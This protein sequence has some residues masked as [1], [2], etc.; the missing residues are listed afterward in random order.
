MTNNNN[1]ISSPSGCKINLNNYGPGSHDAE[2]DSD[3]RPSRA[4]AAAATKAKKRKR[5]KSSGG[6][7][8]QSLHTCYADMDDAAKWMLPGSGEYVEDIIYARL[9]KIMVNKERFEHSWV[10]DLDDPE[11]AAWFPDPRDWEHIC[12]HMPAWP[13][14]D[15]V[16]GEYF[17]RFSEIQTPL[18]L[19]SV[20]LKPCIPLPT[21]KDTTVDVKSLRQKYLAPY[22]AHTLM[23]TLL[24]LFE[25]PALFTSTYNLESWYNSSVW[26]SFF[27][28]GLITIPDVH[29]SRGES[30]SHSCSERKR[31]E[32]DLSIMHHTSSSTP[33]RRP[34]GHK[35]DSIVRYRDIE[36]GAAEHARAFDGTDSSKWTSDT[37]KLVKLLH[38]MLVR[39]RR[40]VHAAE[41]LRQ[42]PLVGLISAGLQYQPLR[43]HYA[44]G[45]VCVLKRHTARCIPTTLEDCSDLLAA[46]FDFWAI[47]TMVLE[48]TRTIDACKEDK[49]S[50]FF[51]QL[52]KGKGTEVPG[53][54]ATGAESVGKKT[55]ATATPPTKVPRLPW[56]VQSDDGGE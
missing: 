54:T 33:A 24:P 4:T 9:N 43:I 11:V 29:V 15:T 55:T 19:F 34:S 23:S 45:Y 32:R 42:V 16:L 22:W 56:S 26:H 53:T 3:E 40:H 28:L 38:D 49:R 47:R 52:A 7:Q 5:T 17:V 6:A 31:S 10:L 48:C 35:Y 13:E 25:N 30:Q 44:Q 18:E 27:D 37:L 36:V 51:Q 46:L 12:E 14:W 39:L 41:A 50:K 8:F 2:S 21:V 20:L 1:T